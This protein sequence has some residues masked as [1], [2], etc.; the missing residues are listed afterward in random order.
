MILAGRNKKTI[1]PVLDRLK[2]DGVSVEFL[3]LDLSS[4]KSVRAA[5]NALKEKHQQ[6]DVL[7][8]NAAIM[9]CPFDLSEDGIEMQFATNFIGPALFTNLLLEAGL[10]KDR[11]VNVSSSASVRRADYLLAPLDDLSYANGQSYHPILA[12]GTSK[13]ALNLYTRSL[14]TKIKPRHI[15]VFSLNPGSI[16]SP[17]Q[18]HLTEEVRSAAFAAARKE[19]P[20]FVPPS[21][22]TLQQGCAAQL[23][24]ALDPSL[25]E[26][27]GAYLDDCQ[28]V[29]YQEHRD[30][31]YATE[32]V[33]QILENLVGHV[34]IL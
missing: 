29:E 21:R 7:V 24:A 9:A 8:N 11:I 28:V 2:T 5:V 27:S 32:R 1:Q 26:Q 16:K 6:I 4:Q 18:R 34:F 20:N 10:I 13:I 14:A 19:N 33:W 31:Y 15:S 25:T 3:Q 30:A 22:K 17:L 12:Y 23:R